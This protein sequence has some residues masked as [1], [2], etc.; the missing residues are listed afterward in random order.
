MRCIQRYTKCVLWGFNLSMPLARDSRVVGV[1]GVVQC[2]IRQLLRSLVWPEFTLSLRYEGFWARAWD[3]YMY[4]WYRQRGASMLYKRKSRCGARVGEPSCLH[5]RQT[6]RPRHLSACLDPTND[7]LLWIHSTP[8]HRNTQ[9]F[10][11]QN[12]WWKALKRWINAHSLNNLE[13]PNVDG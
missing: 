10:D 1:H 8:R 2:I 11:P 7:P 13:N 4:I 3:V 12:P 9:Q 5:S 6:L